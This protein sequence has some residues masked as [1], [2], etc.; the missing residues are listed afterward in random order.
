MRIGDLVRHND[1]GM[2]VVFKL[3]EPT[4]IFSYQIASVCFAKGQ[5]TEL[6]TTTLHLIK[7]KNNIDI[8]KE[9]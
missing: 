7:S 8:K 6:A 2:G 9:A 1:H 5:I 4:V 3:S